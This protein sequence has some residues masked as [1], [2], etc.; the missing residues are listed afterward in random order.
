M[1]HTAHSSNI[2]LMVLLDNGVFDADLELHWCAD[3]VKNCTSYVG[4]TVALE[5]RYSKLMHYLV[6]LQHLCKPP[7]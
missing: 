6:L 2:W 3:Y 5:D 7:L 1:G 4:K